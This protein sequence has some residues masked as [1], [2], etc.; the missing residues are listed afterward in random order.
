VGC[1]P[2]RR[3]IRHGQK[4]PGAIGAWAPLIRQSKR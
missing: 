3:R 4:A 1:P 2:A